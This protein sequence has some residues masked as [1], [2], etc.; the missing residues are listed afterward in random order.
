MRNHS[1]ENDFDLTRLDTEA[2]GNSEVAYFMPNT[3][4]PH[5][6]DQLN[7]KLLV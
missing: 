4:T 5:V 7:R 1:N 2:K 6:A 3:F